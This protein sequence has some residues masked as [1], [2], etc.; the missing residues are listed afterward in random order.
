M[1]KDIMAL[2]RLRCYQRPHIPLI[3]GHPLSPRTNT[4]SSA[5][6]PRPFECISPGLFL[7]RDATASPSTQ[8]QCRPPTTHPSPLTEMSAASDPARVSSSVR[9]HP[10]RFFQDTN[11]V[12][13]ARQLR[14]SRSHSS[15]PPF[16]DSNSGASNRGMY[17]T[18][19]PCGTYLACSPPQPGLRLI[20]LW[21]SSISPSRA[22]FARP[23]LV[24]AILTLL[25]R[26]RWIFGACM[27]RFRGHARGLRIPRPGYRALPYSLHLCIFPLRDIHSHHSRFSKYTP[28]TSVCSFSCSPAAPA[29]HPE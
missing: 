1:D 13:Y 11:A 7:S 4:R 16:L 9:L 3:I 5:T 28:S 22:R 20:L 19:S 2:D 17:I 26:R 24:R 15:P 12:R 29:S 8:P 6:H 18:A 14:Q 21:R 27:R 25:S 10:I 23:R